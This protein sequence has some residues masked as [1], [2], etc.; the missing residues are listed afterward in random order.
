MT[1]HKGYTLRSGRRL[2]GTIRPTETRGVF[3]WASNFTKDRGVT[4]GLDSA[5]S[6]VL[7]EAGMSPRQ[8]EIDLVDVETGKRRSLGSSA[9]DSRARRS[10]SRK[11][12][13]T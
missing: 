7:R 6:V 8:Y 9:R 10:T 13:A 1:E 12:R 3:S 11:G 5:I 4:T 2:L